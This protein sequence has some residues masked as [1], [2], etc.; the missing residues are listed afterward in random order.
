MSSTKKRSEELTGSIGGEVTF[1]VN[2]GAGQEQRET[3]DQQS[4]RITISETANQRS[5]TRSQRHPRGRRGHT[6][7]ASSGNAVRKG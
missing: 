3:T 5:L 6:D 2:D 7:R 1:G 4:R